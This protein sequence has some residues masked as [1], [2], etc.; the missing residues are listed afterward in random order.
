MV[1]LGSPVSVVLEDQEVPEKMNGSMKDPSS[2][3]PVRIL[4][5]SGGRNDVEEV[6]VPKVSK[7]R[8]DVEN[9]PLEEVVDKEDEDPRP[10]NWSD[11]QRRPMDGSY[12]FT[13]RLT[14]EEVLR[15]CQ[16]PHDG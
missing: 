14:V 8:I 7:L 11:G 12:D 15:L 13:R 6:L 2:L 16:W 10:L 3:G 1:S 5:C 9:H 4:A